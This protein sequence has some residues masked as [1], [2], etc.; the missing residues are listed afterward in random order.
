MRTILSIALAA[1]LCLGLL[2]RTGLAE[3]PKA[4][5]VSNFAPAED[6]VALAKE[7]IKDFEGMLATE[8]D[9]NE[10][11]DLIKRNAHTLAVLAVALGL[12]DTPNELKPAAPALVKAAQDL[13]KA[14][15]YASAMAALAAVKSAAD[16]K[17][18][19]GPEL[20]WSTKV[21][22]LGQLMK[23]VTTTDARL[24]RNL[25]RFDRLAAENAQSSALLAVI[26]QAAIADTHEVKD[27]ADLPKWYQWCEDMREAAA[28]VNRA[29][30]AKD[31]AAADAAAKRL[32]QSCDECHAVFQTE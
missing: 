29:V 19:E 32:M 16:G 21:A 5:P 9:F 23:Q 31:P 11:K 25:R 7:F 15:D 2:T 20:N 30:K 13:G 28:G 26:A 17:A 4:P 8:Q 3:P 1:A 18:K 6:L 24:R 12:H 27:P 22:S 14:M 10:K